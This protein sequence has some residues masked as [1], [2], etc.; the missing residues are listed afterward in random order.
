MA[1]TSRRRWWAPHRRL[2]EILAAAVLIALAVWRTWPLAASLSHTV[3]G[4]PWLNFIHPDVYL[5]MWIV[6]WPVQALL[7]AP[8]ELVNAPIFHPAHYAQGYT[9]HMVGVLPVTLPAY[10]FSRNPIF[11]HQFLLLMTFVLSAVTMAALIRFWTGSLLGAIVGGAVFAFAPWRFKYAQHIQLLVTFYVPLAV[12]FSSRY[13]LRGRRRDLLAAGV[14]LG[15]QALSSYALV[16]PLFAALI[17]FWFVH[18]LG[19]RAPL[20]RLVGL[21][22]MA[23]AVTALLAV[24]TIPQIAVRQFGMSDIMRYWN[25]SESAPL[26]GTALAT[27]I[28]P[29]ALQFPGYVPAALALAGILVL[30]VPSRGS[31]RL[32]GRVIVVSMMAFVAPL[33]V[34]SLGPSTEWLAWLWRVV[35]GL[36]QYRHAWR[37]SLL[38]SFA[39]GVLAGGAVAVIDNAVRTWRSPVRLLA[40]AVVWVAT[41]ALVVHSEQRRHALTIPL[42][43]LRPVPPVYQWLTEQPHDASPALLELPAGMAAPRGKRYADPEYVFWSLY[44]NV[45]LINGYAGYAPANYPLVLNLAAQLPSADAL[46]T[47]RRLTGVRWIVVH[48][49]KLTPGERKRWESAENL[50][51]VMRFG[52]DLVLAVEPASENWQSSYQQPPA[53]KTMAGTPLKTLGG[54][55]E[56]EWSTPASV[57]VGQNLAV[58]LTVRNRGRNTWP[59]LSTDPRYQMTVVLYWEPANAPPQPPSST[60]IDA[61]LLGRESAPNQARVPA[62]VAIIIPK[63]VESGEAATVEAAIATPRR[64]GAYNLVA[65]VV[66]GGVNRVVVAR[67]A[68]A[69]RWPVQLVLPEEPSVP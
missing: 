54:F 29:G 41:L 38:S 43:R 2:P 56:I 26:S 10:L 67:G 11:T 47:L 32:S 22:L 13:L 36:A 15:S 20:R 30:G 46:E 44:H 63:D 69:R 68:A 7:S 19:V 61:L 1:P 65:E 50:T 33:V 49:R 28:D 64:A 66:Q 25:P 8:W 45:P 39:V 48:L 24:A 57:M 6:N 37:F 31:L 40:H 27:W 12:L 4:I 62:P 60:P 5:T 23:A 55:A 59:A 17:P 14:A 3:W 16:Y 9:E 53:N 52:D 51:P 34:L 58:R 35:P 21:A 42:M 18:W